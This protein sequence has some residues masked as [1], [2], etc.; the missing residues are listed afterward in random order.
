MKHTIPFLSAFVCAALAATP[1]SGSTG[2]SPIDLRLSPDLTDTFPGTA[3]ASNPYEGHPA[4]NAFD[5][6]VSTRAGRWLSIVPSGGDSIGWLRW[7]F[8][9]GPHVVR[10]YSFTSHV[11]TDE[12]RAPTAWTLEGSNDGG[13]TWTPL[14]A[15]SGSTGWAKATTRVYAF[16][17]AA[18][19]AS[20]RWTFAAHGEGGDQY[21]GLQEIELHATAESYGDDLTE[22]LDPA[23]DDFESRV[24][25]SASGGTVTESSHYSTFSGDRMFDGDINTTD[26]RWLA[27]P[28]VVGTMPDL[29][30]RFSGTVSGSDSLAP[31]EPACA[32]DGDVTTANGRWLSKIQSGEVKA[33][34]SWTFSDG[35][36]AVGG[37][38][39]KNV[40]TGTANRNPSAWRVEGSNDGGATWTSLA[41]VSGQQ[42]W[43]LGE[44][45]LFRLPGDAA[46]ST[47]RFSITQDGGSDYVGLSEIELYSPEDMAANTTGIAWVQYEAAEP[48]CADVYFLR[49]Y[50][51]QWGVEQRCSVSWR[52]L[53]SDDGVSWTTLHRMVDQP[54]WVRHEWRAFGLDNARA[55]RF[56]RLVLD[57]VGGGGGQGDNVS[58]AGWVGFSEWT[59]YDARGCRVLCSPTYDNGSDRHCIGSK[60]FD[61]DTTSAAGEW[62][63]VP[64]AVNPRAWIVYRF[65]Q[66]VLV[67][68]YKLTT[69]A[70]TDRSRNRSPTAWT[71]AGSNDRG[72]TWTEI[73]SRTK[74]AWSPGESVV[75]QA[76][77]PG[78]YA[79][80]RLGV[81]GLG[82]DA[83]Y[84]G[85]QEI[86]L[87][88][89]RSLGTIVIVR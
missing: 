88:G 6:D 22:T 66:R 41:E 65:D 77:S 80:I 53:A 57:S 78:R 28:S 15:V 67:D 26:G 71:L 47:Y 81:T 16:K 27:I 60:A 70:A 59:L 31:F 33:W 76:A 1:A 37:Y 39:F 55:W 83:N 5:N 14:D 12:S 62:M 24:V 35:P 4:A 89:S 43:G 58:N 68:A 21:F 20:Y 82:S 49:S 85:L 18:A 30:D 25:T 32:F 45:R 75:H 10:A 72:A 42:Y 11:E 52:V 34:V 7:D 56:W 48:L 63:A 29:T 23:V 44:E 64:L 2:V 51:D 19:Y 69:F 38:G 17:N 74:N 54:S 73:D 13:A 46:F 61:G 87:Y 50:P 40:A 8:S 3:T 36:R 79:W 9:D 86:E 84:V